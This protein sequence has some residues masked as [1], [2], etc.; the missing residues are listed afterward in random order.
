MDNEKLHEIAR[1]LEPLLPGWSLDWDPVNRPRYAL[2]VNDEGAGIHVELTQ[3]TSPARLAVTAR[4]PHPFYPRPE[5]RPRITISS[6]R[7]IEAI[8]ADV[9][10]RFIPR[11]LEAFARVC[12]RKRRAEEYERQRKAILAG[13]AEILQEPVSGDGGDPLSLRPGRSLHLRAGRCLRGAGQSGFL[14]R[15]RGYRPRDLQTAGRDQKMMAQTN[16][17]IRYTYRDGANYKFHG[18]AVL[19]GTVTEE[20]IHP[21]LHEGLYFIPGDVG[22]PSLHP[23]H[24]EFDE[25]LDHPWHEFDSASSIEAEPPVGPMAVPGA[26]EFLRR[27]R[28]AAQTG[29]PGQREDF[30]WE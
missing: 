25:D 16:T 17:C 4:Y 8:A 14:R 2:F 9:Q 6:A 27:L 15:P 5:S 7:S 11:Y 23:T 18:A 24:C 21:H 30:A 1:A 13:L 28:A 3:R 10:R 20:E 12:E 22:L 19:A 26:G 29:W